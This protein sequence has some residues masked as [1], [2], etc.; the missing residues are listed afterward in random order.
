[1]RFRTC[2][3]AKL[4]SHTARRIGD[5][6]TQRVFQNDFSNL[7]RQSIPDSI[8]RQSRAGVQGDF[9]EASPSRSRSFFGHTEPLPMRNI[10]RASVMSFVADVT[11]CD[12]DRSSGGHMVPA[13]PISR[14]TQCAGVH[15][16]LQSSPLFCG[17][18][19]PFSQICANTDFAG[20]GIA[21]N[22]AEGPRVPLIR[23]P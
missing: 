22:F 12:T 20:D 15:I 3:L 1:M 9:Y 11:C 2:Q 14:E 19:N 4:A 5:Y 8:N 7:R 6:H 13:G 10:L 17:F 16:F 21:E 18:Q 23:D